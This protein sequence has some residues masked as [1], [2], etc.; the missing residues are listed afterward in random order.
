MINVA[1]DI[2]GKHRQLLSILE[3]KLDLH[4][5]HKINIRWIRDL[6]IYHYIIKVLQ[7]TLEYYINLSVAKVSLGDIN[8]TGFNL[9]KRLN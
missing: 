4:L 7:G 1:S 6:K 3:I 5:I 2:R 8:D 9:I